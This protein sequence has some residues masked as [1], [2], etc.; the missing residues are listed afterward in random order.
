MN[1]PSTR[2]SVAKDVFLYMLMIA[3]LYV[4]V[5]AFLVLVF[6]YVNH[7]FP[8]VLDYSYG[9]DLDAIRFSTAALVIVFPVY[10][11]VSWLLQREVHAEPEKADLRVRKWLLYLTL[12]LSALVIIIDLI[13]L[14]YSFLNGDL[15]AR[16]ILKVL[17]ILIVAGTVFGYYLWEVLRKEMTKSPL[18]RI[19]GIGTAVVVFVS[20][21]AGFFIIG[22][23]FD[24]RQVRF[25]S[26]RV[27]DLQSIQS[28]LVSYWQAKDKLPATLDDLKNDISG[29]VPPVDPGTNK[30][31][32]Y[33]P[34]GSLSFELCATF[35]TA[36]SSSRGRMTEYAG[37]GGTV[38]SW[39]HAAGRTCFT[40]TIDPAFYKLQGVGVPIK[41]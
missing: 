32:E 36:S 3:M 39:S 21:A 19:L 41:G 8:D 24:Q 22:S 13:T 9:A 25:D 11:F 20:I 28:E 27:S 15:T 12:F 31:Y 34:K 35:E 2:G 29:F 10:L 14:V 33:A 30:P 1:N 6:Q 40:H 23:P 17:I 5:A 16:F 4:S 37:P 7:L 38:E 18:P 26:R